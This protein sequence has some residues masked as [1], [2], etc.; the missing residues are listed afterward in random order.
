[1]RKSNEMQIGKAGEYLACADLIMKGMIAY[2]SEQGLPYDV[3]IDAGDR[4]LKCQ[5]KT[6]SAPRIIPQRGKENYAYIF[7]IKRCGK[8]G[9]GRYSDG[10][11][12]VFALVELQTRTVGYL[13]T[14]D[15]PDTINL[16]VDSLKGKYYDET[17]LAN[18]KNV[19]ELKRAGI[20]QVDASKKLGIKYSTVNRLWKE[21]YVPHKTG[22]RYFSDL[23]REREWFDGI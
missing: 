3:V 13:V 1:M 19:L 16:R 5:V 14:K 21:G 15:M 4:L 20:S 23:Y 17:S 8:G 11:I 9:A 2:P 6:T 22:A 7:N 18:H 12:D 10:E